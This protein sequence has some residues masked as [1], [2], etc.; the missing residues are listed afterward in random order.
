ML[1]RLAAIALAAIG[2]VLMSVFVIPTDQLAA[3]ADNPPTS[4]PTTKA[5]RQI[6]DWNHLVVDVQANLPKARSILRGGCERLIGARALDRAARDL[7][8]TP[9]DV[10]TPRRAAEVVPDDHGVPT[11]RVRF[12]PDY[13]TESEWNR[14]KAIAHEMVHIAMRLGDVELIIRWEWHFRRSIR[15]NHPDASTAL[16]DFLFVK[17]C[18][19]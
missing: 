16:D 10:Y 13:Y 8:P 4:R 1:V 3:V 18:T 9:G 6:R 14:V 12:G 19:I 11:N 5:P 7:K 17:G 15:G 2:T